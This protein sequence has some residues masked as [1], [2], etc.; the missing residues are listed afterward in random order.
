[1]RNYEPKLAL[2]PPPPPGLR[3]RLVSGEPDVAGDTFYRPLDK[4]A[5]KGRAK[6][7]VVEVAGT[8]QAMRTIRGIYE[9]GNGYW[10][11]CEVWHDEWDGRR[12]DEGASCENV[13]V[14]GLEVRHLGAGHGRTV[15]CWRGPGREWLHGTRA[16]LA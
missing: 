8:E 5:R 16:V 10:D 7:M 11:G 14:E 12:P 3:E 6:I 4:L 13:G 2:V 1:M 9:D 15:V